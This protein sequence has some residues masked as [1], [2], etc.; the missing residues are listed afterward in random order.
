MM[1]H[2]FFII[3]FKLSKTNVVVRGLVSEEMVVSDV[4]ENHKKYCNLEKTTRHFTSGQVLAYVT[5]VSCFVFESIRLKLL[6]L[7][8]TK[9]FYLQCRIS[10]VVN[11]FAYAC[12]NH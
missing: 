4:L 10:G 7:R 6:K 5:P 12:H 9:A 1:Q 2:F 3:Q 11:P 8:S